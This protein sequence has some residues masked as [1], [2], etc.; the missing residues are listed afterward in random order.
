MVLLCLTLKNLLFSEIIETRNMIVSYYFT[1]LTP[2]CKLM[3]SRRFGFRYLPPQTE[4]YISG[5]AFDVEHA[6]STH[7]LGR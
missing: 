5:M 6:I 3:H 1:K 7:T 4:K 2:L